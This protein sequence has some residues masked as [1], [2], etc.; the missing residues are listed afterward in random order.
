VVVEA[1]RIVMFLKDLK[2]IMN[3]I[4]RNVMEVSMMGKRK[5]NMKKRIIE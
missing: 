3:I 1:V 2:E 5:T 4:N